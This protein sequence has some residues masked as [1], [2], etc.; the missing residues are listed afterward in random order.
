[1]KKPL[2]FAHRGALHHAP[3][4]TAIAFTKAA[5]FGA[6]GV[7]T[8]IHYTADHELV[9]IHNYTVDATSNGS[10]A[11]EQMTLAQ[12]KELDFGAYKGDTFAGQ[13]ILT[14]DEFLDLVKDFDQINVE[15]KG[16]ATE[17]ESY[18]QKVIDTIQHKGLTDKVLISGFDHKLLGMC[19]KACPEIR[20]GLIMVQL[21]A[22]KKILD[23]ARALLPADVPLSAIPK[24]ALQITDEAVLRGLGLTPETA[25]TVIGDMLDAISAWMPGLTLDQVVAELQKQADIMGYI[26]SI[27]YKVDFV[28]PEYRTVL[29]APQLVDAL[30]QMGIGVSV[31][32]PDDPAALKKLMTMNLYGVITN[33]PDVALGV[34]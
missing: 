23:G 5:E 17:Q 27:D 28:H 32:T 31:W 24:G 29:A 21:M 22:A 7:E 20:V 1:M 9:V 10:G 19:K 16:P 11:V 6:Q 8:D 33:R 18:V 25:A 4:N 30:N 13:R 34:E 3:Q 12:L 26:Q 2:V 15:L 14:L